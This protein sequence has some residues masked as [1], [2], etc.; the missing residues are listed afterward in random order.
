MT[1]LP[2]APA[3]RLQ[4]N[5]RPSHFEYVLTDAGHAKDVATAPGHVA[6]V[7]ALVFDVLTSAQRAHLRTIGGRI[8]DHV[9]AGPSPYRATAAGLRGC[10]RTASIR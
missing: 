10:L 4:R 3:A 5:A 7:R 2:A 8:T 9:N 1:L 6:T